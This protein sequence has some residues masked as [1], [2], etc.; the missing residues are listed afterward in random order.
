MGVQDERQLWK[1]GKRI[2]EGPRKDD[3]SWR[4]GGHKR[5]SIVYRERAGSGNRGGRLGVVA[6]W[7][8]RLR[9]RDTAALL[10]AARVVRGRQLRQVRKRGEH[11]VP[12]YESFHGKSRDHGLYNDPAA[13][14]DLQRY[15]PVS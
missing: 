10:D 4:P 8:W 11:H 1:S 6:D 14:T 13:R 3:R 2:V 9:L 12:H 7:R 15:Q 5:A